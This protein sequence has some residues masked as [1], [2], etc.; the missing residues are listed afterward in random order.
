M[1][2]PLIRHNDWQVDPDEPM[3]TADGSTI[4]QG[5]P[6]YCFWMG[7]VEKL[8]VDTIGKGFVH[9]PSIAGKV[10]PTNLYESPALCFEALESRKMKVR[11]VLSGLQQKIASGEIKFQGQL[12]ISEHGTGEVRLQDGDGQDE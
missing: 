1:T 6:A 9:C 11:Q 8:V 3:I 5:M 2:R 4:E 10:R 7:E 12:K